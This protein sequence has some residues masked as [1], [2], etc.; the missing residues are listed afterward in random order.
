[1]SNA[2]TIKNAST[3]AWSARA[4]NGAT[5]L[6]VTLDAIDHAFG[7]SGDW[8]VLAHHLRKGIDAGAKREVDNI[9][10]VI[11]SVVPDIKIVAD[12]KQPTGIRIKMKGAVK[13]NHATSIVHDLIE[14]K[15]SI[16]GTA[17]KNA[18]MPEEEKEKKEKTFDAK[19]WAQRQ[20]KNNPD[21][22]EAMIAALQALR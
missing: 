13:N 18:L 19:A 11:R 22:L 7:D 1:M 15:V 9:K 3:R 14:R 8:T 21:Q 17:I 2:K 10:L 6:Q 12:D 20:V 4:N 5:V 16:S